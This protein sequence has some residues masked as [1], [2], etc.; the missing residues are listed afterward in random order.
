M[1]WYD[2]TCYESYGIEILDV[3]YEQVYTD[4]V[5]DQL[6]HLNPQQ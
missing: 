4:E 2:P 1:D 3:K 6:E 5:V